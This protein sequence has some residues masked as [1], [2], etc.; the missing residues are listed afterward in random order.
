[1]EDI[2]VGDTVA[3]WR[4]AYGFLAPARVTK[5]T[6]CYYEVLNNNRI[7]T[8]GINRTRKVNSVANEDGTPENAIRMTETDSD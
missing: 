6:P 2:S 1:M 4:D 8:S 7:K 5:V 3:I